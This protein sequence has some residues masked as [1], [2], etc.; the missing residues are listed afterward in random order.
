MG[1]RTTLLDT[2]LGTVEVRTTLLHTVLGTV[3]DC[4]EATGDCVG[5]TGDI[6]YIICYSCLK[7]LGLVL[8]HLDLCKDT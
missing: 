8:R 4:A 7:H 1:V 3:G 2:V 5:A 6:V